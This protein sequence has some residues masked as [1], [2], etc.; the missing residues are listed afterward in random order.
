MESIEFIRLRLCHAAG[1]AEDLQP[2]KA[3]SI[4]NN[5][6]DAGPEFGILE[7]TVDGCMALLTRLT[8]V[9]VA[10]AQAQDAGIDWA[11]NTAWRVSPLPNSRVP[12]AGLFHSDSVR[13]LLSARF[14]RHHHQSQTA[15]CWDVELVAEESCPFPL[16]HLVAR[17]RTWFPSV[18]VIQPLRRVSTA[19]PSQRSTSTLP[20]VSTAPAGAARAGNDSVET[21]VL[22]PQRPEPGRAQAEPAPVKPLLRR[23]PRGAPLLACNRW[24]EAEIARLPDPLRYTSLYRAW[25]LRYQALRGYAPQ[26]PR[27]SF[28]AAAESALGRLGFR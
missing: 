4:P 28:R 3:D 20:P 11:N 24:L 9:H 14:Y 19:L 25:L 13:P 27:R 7:P 22:G 17:L 6:P 10:R 15:R 2:N 21:R 5:A 23:R 12:A 18:E 8:A 16:P 26:D 1:T